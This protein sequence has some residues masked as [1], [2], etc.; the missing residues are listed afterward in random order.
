[1]E[2]PGSVSIGNYCDRCLGRFFSSISTGLTNEQRGMIARASLA[3]FSG[4]ENSFS[5]T[6]TICKN[7][8]GELEKYA[9]ICMAKVDT[10]SFDT[11]RLGSI[12]PEAAIEG[13]KELHEVLGV[14]G[15]TIKKEFNRELGK[16]FSSKTGKEYE[17][18]TPDMEITVDTRYDTVK[19]RSESIYV[20]GTYRKL[21][22]GI[23]Q[24]RWIHGSGDTVESLIG[25]A[26]KDMLEGENY[27]LHGAGREDVDVR[28]LG[29]GREFVIEVSQP[30][31]RKVSLRGLRNRVNE[32]GKV[33][34]HNLSVTTKSRIRDLKLSRNDK[35][36]RMKVESGEKIDA[37]KLRNC[38]QSMN[39]KVIYQRTPLR[40]SRRRADMVRERRLIESG[41]ISTRGKTATL[42]MKAEAGTYIKE[43]VSGD[44][45]RTTP[46]VSSEYGESLRVIELDVT[47]I[48]R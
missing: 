41:V 22:R 6:C 20:Y 13:E 47:R 29:N 18:N 21:V 28:M 32:S 1:M 42:L 27:F 37:E 14:S 43:L 44:N 10:F 23:P 46:S 38:I 48:H 45:G 4:D 17:M 19:I 5:G 11:F 39:G 40:V 8:F 15:E 12:F 3:L 26:L 24:T 31:L 33:S 30:R 9:R 36:Y 35:T 2:K 34:I 16:I 7:T 25:E